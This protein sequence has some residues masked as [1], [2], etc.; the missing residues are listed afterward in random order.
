MEELLLPRHPFDQQ[1]QAQL[2]LLRSLPEELRAE[3]ARLLRLGNAAFCYQQQAEGLVTEEDY[4]DWLA[5]LPDTMR[6]AMEQ[7]GFEKSKSTLPLRRHA[8]ERRD[9]GYDEFMQATVSAEDWAYEQS[10][11]KQER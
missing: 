1:H 6:R 2:K 8:L 11:R 7:E 3:H 9:Q 5:G 10:M 4:R